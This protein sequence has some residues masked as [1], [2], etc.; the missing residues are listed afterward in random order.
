MIWA[1][2]RFE[3]PHSQTSSDMCIPSDPSPNLNPNSW[4]DM[5]GEVPI[6]LGFWE[7]GCPKSGDAH[8][9]VTP[10][11]LAE[12]VWFTKFQP[13]V[14]SRPDSNLFTFSMG[15]IDCTKVWHKTYPICDAP[16]WDRR[17]VASR[18]HRNRAATTLNFL[19]VNRNPIQYDVRGDAKAVRYSV[20]IDLVKWL[21]H[22]R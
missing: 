9:T 8:I 6:S 19:W 14:G 21:Y 10:A 13:L 16:C 11:L 1:S 2:P 12:R 18:C 22:K 5:R 4:G 7:C 15:R 3:H 20:N 17:S